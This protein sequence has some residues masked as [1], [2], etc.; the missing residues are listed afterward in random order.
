MQPVIAIVYLALLTWGGAASAQSTYSLS[1]SRHGDTPELSEEKVRSILTDA[2]KMLRK[3]S[4]HEDRPADVACNVSFTLKGPIRTFTSPATPGSIV[5][6]QH[7]D[8]V[9]GVDSNVGGVDFH[10]KVVNTIGF[11]RPG[12]GQFNGCA[13]PPEFRSIIVVHPRKHA[14]LS[15]SVVDPFPDHLLWAHEFGH[16]TGLGHRNDRRAL[17]TGCPL[18][19]VFSNVPDGQVRVSRDEC[20]CLR[21]G[22]GSCPLP[23]PT[24]CQEPGR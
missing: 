18:N 24:P 2:S 6:E 4:H 23:Q 13:F 16:L 21:S 20:N 1:V 12:A 17:M 22:L 11:C 7:R 19:Q 3:N 10:V 5:T 9:H 14:D 8:A 15:G